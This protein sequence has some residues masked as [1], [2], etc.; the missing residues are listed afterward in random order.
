MKILSKRNIYKTPS[1]HLVWEWENII[2]KETTWNL[3]RDNIF[4]AHPRI[5][6]ELPLLHNFCPPSCPSFMFEMK[7]PNT[8]SRNRY[9]R[10]NIF[11]CIIDYFL[12]DDE[13]LIFEKNFSEHRVVFISS[14]EVFNRL[15]SLGTHVPILHL[16]LSLPDYYYY[17]PEV[18]CEKKYDVVLVGR[19][20]PVLKHYLEIYA[21]KHPSFVYV[22]E[23][24]RP[25]RKYHYYSTNGDYVGYF[26]S[27][28]QYMSLISKSKVALYSTPGIDGGEVRT[29]GYNQVTPKFLEYIASGCNI[30]SRWQDNADTDYFQLNKFSDNIQS[31]GQ[32]EV[33]MDRAL[34]VRPNKQMYAD[35]LSKH[36]TSSRVVLLKEY[37]DNYI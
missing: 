6:R 36:Y 7:A 11:P 37:L 2:A 9:N 28:K 14:K 26:E 15:I 17:N 18:E 10:S 8:V 30:I 4:L 34:E 24:E 23:D 21:K 27:R 33:A 16:P 20:N 22:L 31:Y 12:R 29:N 5:Q 1:W 19:Q 25:K 13:L 3:Y 32:F 35:Y